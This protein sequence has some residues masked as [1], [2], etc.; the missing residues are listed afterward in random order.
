MMLSKCCTQYIN[1]FVKSSSNHRTGKGQSPSY[2]SGRVELKNV[3]TMR[4]LHSSPMLVRLYSKSCMLSFSIMWTKNFQMSKLGLKKAEE[5]EFKLSTFAGS[6][7]KQGIPEKHLHLFYWLHWNFWPYS[8][9][10]SCSVVSDPWP[11]NCST[12][13]LPVHHQLPKFTQTHVHWVSDAIQPSH[14]LSSPS[15]PAC[16][17]SFP[18][19]GSFPVTQFFAS[20]GQSTGVSASTSVLPMNIQDWSP[21]GWTGWISLQ[22]KGLSR[23]FSNTTVQKHQFFRAQLSL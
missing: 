16:P 3:Q 17:Q 15:P 23:V 1:I 7:R 6:W 19:S 14:P 22:S 9:Q 10:F 11:M 20:H 21:L 12:P 13:G 18:A 2:L 8:V 5:T 4:K